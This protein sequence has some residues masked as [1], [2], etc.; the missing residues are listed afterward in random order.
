MSRKTNLPSRLQ[1]APQ[2]PQSKD[3]EM[4]SAPTKMAV[5]PVPI[6]PTL[7]LRSFHHS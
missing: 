5:L 1:K 4:I 3:Q 7:R 6:L 2:K